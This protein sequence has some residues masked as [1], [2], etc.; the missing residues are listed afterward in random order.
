[1]EGRRMSEQTLESLK[2]GTWLGVCL[3]GGGGGHEH[4][5]GHCRQ[6][7]LDHGHGLDG[8]GCYLDYGN[9]DHVLNSKIGGY[10]ISNLLIGQ[11][12]NLQLQGRPG[13]SFYA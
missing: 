10:D 1:M 6:D 5:C 4:G 13:S 2:I 12:L 9:G 3:H 8:H 11:K 7:H